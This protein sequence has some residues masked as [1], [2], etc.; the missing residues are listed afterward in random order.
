MKSKT[1]YIDIVHSYIRKLNLVKK[2][3]LFILNEVT[4]SVT[5]L[6]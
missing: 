6:Y 5:F 1:Q 2:N 4:F 3:V